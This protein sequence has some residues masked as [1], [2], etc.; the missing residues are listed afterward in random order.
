M[1]LPDGRTAVLLSTHDQTLLAADARAVLD[2]VERVPCDVTQVAAQ[3]LGT[4]RVRRHRVAVRAADRDELTAGLRAVIDGT[5]HPLVTGSARRVAAR[6]A[7]V[8]PGQGGQWPSM[9][10]DAYRLLPVYR[11][12]ADRVDAAFQGAGFP[13]PLR[14]LTAAGDQDSVSQIELQGAQFIH[15][16]AL[17]AVW[18]S[19]GVL[20][21]LT[22]GHSLGEIA[23]AYVADSITVGDA[24]AVL[25]ARAYAVE[26]LT[27]GYRLAVL[28]A[29]VRSA[30]ELIATTPGWLEISAINA[31]SSVVVAGEQ[32]AIATLVATLEQRGQFVRELAVDFPA[33]TSALEPLHDELLRRLPRSAFAESAV[34]FIG[35][36]T[37][38]VVPAGTDF[39]RYW[40]ANLRN[41][42][43]FDQAV[44]SAIAGGAGTF[45]E[46]S[47]HPALLFALTDAADESE[48]FAADPAVIVGS[49][50]RD[51]PLTDRL[52]GNIVATA[53]ADP[54]YRWADLL[55]P[56]PA[57]LR[58]FP[59][60]P[61]RNTH[62]WATA[63]PL[64]PVAGLTVAVES[65]QRIPARSRNT[66]EQRAIAVLGSGTMADRLREAI[67]QRA[68]AR[69]C[70]PSDAEILVVPAPPSAPGDAA[71]AVADLA[72][73]IDGGLLDYVAAIGPGCRDV[74][75]VTA[76]AERVLPADPLADPGQAGLAAMH[77]CIAFEH[78]DQRFNHLD[79]PSTPPVDGGWG[80][81]VNAI[82]GQTGEIALRDNGTAVYRRTVA[83]DTSS[84]P[85][86]PVES[87]LLDNVVITGGSGTVG[88]AFARHLADRGARRIV[89]LSRRGVE[90]AKLDQLRLAHTAEITAPRCDVADRREL[91]AAAVEHAA[92][93]ATLVIHA[94]GSAALIDRSGTTGSTLL[95]NA[96]AKVAGLENLAAVW[97]IRDDARILLCSSVTGVWGGK[98]VAAYAAANRMLDVLA[99]RLRD[100]GRRCVAVRFGLWEGSRIIDAAEISQAERMGLRQMKPDSAVEASMYDYRQDPVVLAADPDRLRAFLGAAD[101]VEAERPAEAGNTTTA[102][103]AA[104]AVRSQLAVVLDVDADTVD[105]DSSLFDLGVDSLLALDLRNRLKRL[106]GRTVALATLLGGI[107]GTDLIAD[108]ETPH[109]T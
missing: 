45:A 80:P 76:G 46:M 89:L 34:Q 84:V 103:G 47:A 30:E 67:A 20:P 64:P 43:R 23:A 11:A 92:G 3:V 78:A 75:I 99:D 44:R 22:I 91:E 65:W 59:G 21:D 35:S 5:D 40:Y 15:A 68:E 6:T 63:E 49:G 98:E 27:G 53:V 100:A 57:P 86:W 88:L 81:A 14:F 36:A 90:P 74:W 26:S 102:P 66:A 61:M 106:T 48:R 101:S 17:A 9:G 50:R 32:D 29:D 19:C 83:D 4:R 54:G 33:H 37:G 97:P 62:L 95:E 73:G 55:G 104:D 13:S 41:V 56:R 28:G 38:G 69:I 24:V 42:I 51:E 93:A 2:Y 107:T 7:F 39:G 82:L 96:T 16:V 71:T 87:G 12:E 72:D 70:T 77:R 85:P 1:S 18:R 79:L 25:A 60:A 105:L 52:A 58:G 94:A 108:L 109:V 8:F 10:A 31:S